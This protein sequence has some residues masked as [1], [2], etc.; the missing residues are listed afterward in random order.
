MKK[1][2]VLVACVLTSAP[3]F[4]T[5]W[6]GPYTIST[7]E[8]GDPI[9]YFSTTSS[10]ANPDGCASPTF[11]AFDLA[12]NNLMTRVIAAGLAAKAGG[13]QVRFLTS[14]CWGGYIHAYRIEIS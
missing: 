9:T 6:I 8:L 4:A 7:V 2:L 13:L 11:I 12:D 3:S 1:L 10:L 5:G 14:G